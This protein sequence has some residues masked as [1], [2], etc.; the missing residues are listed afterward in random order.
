MNSAVPGHEHVVALGAVGEHPE[1]PRGDERHVAGQADDPFGGRRQ[2]RGVE[3][4]RGAGVGQGV[5]DHRQ[6]QVV[7]PLR[8]RG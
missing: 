3:A 1:E 4:D 2:D 6:A 7:E 8:L 5:V